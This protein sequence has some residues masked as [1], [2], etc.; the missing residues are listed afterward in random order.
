M[1]GLKVA[2]L[3]FSVAQDIKEISYRFRLWHLCLWLCVFDICPMGA[4]FS[5]QQH[6]TPNCPLATP[7]SLLLYPYTQI[8]ACLPSTVSSKA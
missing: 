8:P 4:Q 2:A 3:P 6:L 1:A 5:A 7:S